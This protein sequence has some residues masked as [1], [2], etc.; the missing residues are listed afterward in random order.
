MS[1]RRI[2]DY[3]KGFLPNKYLAK[4]ESISFDLE[5]AKKHTGMSIGYPA[6]NL[7]YYSVL[8]S[9]PQGEREVV[10]VETG[11]NMGFST[12][13]LA[14]ALCDAKKKGIVYTVELEAA[15]YN[16]SK[17]NVEKAGLSEYVKSHL[18]DSLVFLAN[19]SEKKDYINFAFLDGNHDFE[20][21][22]KE[23]AIIHPLIATCRGKVYFDNTSEGG[24]ATA[25]KYIKTNYKGNLIEFGNCSWKPPGNAIWQPD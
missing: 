4:L 11:T 21:V 13:I 24:V 8:C 7:L 22:I 19:L 10:I 3:N 12:I 16:S 15:D 20:Y 17:V 9:M 5:S 25:L 1:L 6:W 14:Q 18:G 23:Y 2:F